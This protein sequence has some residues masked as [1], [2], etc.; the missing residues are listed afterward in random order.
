MIVLFYLLLF[1]NT[2][3]FLSIG[4]DKYR[5]KNYKSRVS[6]QTFLVLV[7]IGGTIGSG[8]GMLFFRHK[9]AKNS[10]LIKFYGIVF[11]QILIS[12]LYLCNPFKK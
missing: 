4:Y 6:E 7:L 2:I 9:T 1:L 8:L 10:Y 11:F 12:W 3:S 5:A